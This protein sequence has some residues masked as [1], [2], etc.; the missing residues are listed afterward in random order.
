MEE[1]RAENA[2]LKNKI[3][4]HRVKTEGNIKIDSSGNLGKLN[5]H[6]NVNIINKNA[7]VFNLLNKAEKIANSEDGNGE[8]K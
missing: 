6:S 5:A 3:Q 8:E 1:L 4:L 7:G 2:S